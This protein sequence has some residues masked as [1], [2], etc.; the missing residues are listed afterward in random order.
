[1][2]PSSF[3]NDKISERNAC[4][5]DVSLL[6]SANKDIDAKSVT[7]LTMY[8]NIRLMITTSSLLTIHGLYHPLRFLSLPRRVG[9]QVA[10]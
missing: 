3:K 9:F 1:M 7:A 8:N 4:C 2:N 10:L 5:S 6:S